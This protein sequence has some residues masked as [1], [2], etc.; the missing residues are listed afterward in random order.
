MEPEKL[1]MLRAKADSKVLQEFYLSNL[2][3]VINANK[4]ENAPEKN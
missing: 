3:K 4:L 1:R 2:E